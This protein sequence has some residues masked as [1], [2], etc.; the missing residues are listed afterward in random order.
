MMFIEVHI[1]GYNE[2]VHELI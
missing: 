2:D 1:Y